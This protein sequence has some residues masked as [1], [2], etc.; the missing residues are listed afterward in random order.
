MQHISTR[1]HSGSST[2]KTSETYQFTSQI[3]ISDYKPF[4][5]DQEV[6]LLLYKLHD[7]KFHKIV[8]LKITGHIRITGHHS[9]YAVRIH[10]RG[11]LQ[12]IGHI[13]VRVQLKITGHQSL[14]SAQDNW[15][16]Q[17]Q[18]CH[19]IQD[20]MTSHYFRMHQNTYSL[21]ALSNH[22]SSE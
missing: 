12:I 17:D 21:C 5:Y 1:I 10:K 15:T 11:L 14:C 20:N 3:G 9:L 16:Y 8:Q 4:P 22:I 2:R 18:K 7:Q 6:H 13:T 19:R